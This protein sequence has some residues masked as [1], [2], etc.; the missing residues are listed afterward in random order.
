MFFTESSAKSAKFAGVLYTALSFRRRRNLSNIIVEML[1]A[2][3][4][5]F[6]II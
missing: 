1:S 3:Q 6:R 2:R 5:L 4:T